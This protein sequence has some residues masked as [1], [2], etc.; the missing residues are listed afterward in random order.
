MM[1]RNPIV[2]ARGEKRLISIELSGTLA[3][4]DSLASNPTVKAT[5]RTG[6][7]DVSAGTTDALIASSPAPAISGTAVTFWTVQVPE[8]YTTGRYDIEAAA[9]T[10]NGEVIEGYPPLTVIIV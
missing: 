5:R 4:G 10:A 3:S 9:T 2:V 6:S 1:S 7:V 8:S